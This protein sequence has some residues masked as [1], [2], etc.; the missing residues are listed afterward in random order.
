MKILIIGSNGKVGQKLIGHLKKAGHEV[1]GMIRSEEQSEIIENLGGIPIVAD[2][3][4]NFSHSYH[5]MEVIIFTAGSGGHTGP[6]KTISVDQQGAIKSIELAEELGIDRFIMVSAQGARSPEAPSPIQHYF[7]AKAIADN[8]LLKSTL[9]Y[10][11]MRPGRLTDEPSTGN[12][13]TGEFF[14]E[15][16]TTS[17]D[18]LARYISTIINDRTTF[19]KVIEIFDGD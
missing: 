17:R 16:G 3:E 14:Q 7:K 15:K 10:T 4:K 9:N 6:E 18:E 12:I 11:I 13:K 8:V 19:R 1:Y 5:H 2:L